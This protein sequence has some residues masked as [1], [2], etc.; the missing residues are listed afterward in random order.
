MAVVTCGVFR[1]TV[2]LEVRCSYSEDDLIRSQ[3]AV[4]IETA[5]AIAVEWRTPAELKGFASQTEVIQ[6]A[7]ASIE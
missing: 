1:T 4:E 3:F 5:R 7:D 2:G 6:C